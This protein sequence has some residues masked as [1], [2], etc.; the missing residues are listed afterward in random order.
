MAIKKS[1]YTKIKRKRVRWVYDPDTHTSYVHKD[2]GSG[3]LDGRER[4]PGKGDGTGVRRV[5][6]EGHRGQIV[7]RVRSPAELRAIHAKSKKK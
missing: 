7:G 5:I 4:V 6:T 3:E 2:D 1:G